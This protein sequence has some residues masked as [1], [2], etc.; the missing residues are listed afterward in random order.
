MAEFLLLRTLGNLLIDQF[1]DPIEGN[2]LPLKVALDGRIEDA[3]DAAQI[4]LDLLYFLCHFQ[5]EGQI[6]FLIATEVVRA[7]IPDLTVTS[8][9]TVALLELR[10][11]P[12]DIVMDDP[13][14]ALLHVD[15]F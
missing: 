14:A 13:T 2:R 11:G 12:R 15:A 6:F 10:W 8:D 7:D 3:L 4:L 9:T 5:E 1:A